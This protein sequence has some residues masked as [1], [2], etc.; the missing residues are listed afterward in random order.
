[1]RCPDSDEV[2]E[3]D[4]TG[5]FRTC[6]DPDEVD[7]LDAATEFGGCPESGEV[8]KW[9]RRAPSTRGARPKL[10]GGAPAI[11]R[12]FSLPGHDA[13]GDGGYSRNRIGRL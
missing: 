13:G 4:A 9:I 10:G 7:E 6:P 3:V 2:D 5:A 1:M 11:F 8:T 12:S